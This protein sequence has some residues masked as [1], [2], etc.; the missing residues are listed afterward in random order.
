MKPMKTSAVH[1]LAALIACA[2]IPFFAAQAKAAD[3]DSYAEQLSVMTSADQALRG[4]QDFLRLEEPRQ[5]KLVDHIMLVD[6][7]NTARLK[8]LVT[9][10]GWPTKSGH[11]AK[12]VGDAWL[13]AQH[14]DH[15]IAFQ[16]RAL[17]L[18][19]QAAQA[20]EAAPKNVA[21]L[22]D[23]I[24]VAEKRPQPYGTQLRSKGTPCDLEFAPMDDREKVEARR[25]TLGLPT[26]DKYREQV[27]LMTHC[28]R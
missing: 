23:R 17:A 10:C 12:A 9:H 14:A 16:K 2:V 18:I 1:F 28:Q 27:L 11:G 21:Y 26:L 24:A 19:E 13:L 15:D 5:R 8:A 3:C 25:K 4:R 6:R 20:G 7:T 22:A